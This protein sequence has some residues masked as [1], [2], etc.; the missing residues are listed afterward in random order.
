MDFMKNCKY[1]KKKKR[2]ETFN[3]IGCKIVYVEVVWF[4]L[5]TNLTLTFYRAVFFRKLEKIFK[6]NGFCQNH[7]GEKQLKD[8]SKGITN[9]SNN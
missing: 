6:K 7:L 8:N 2:S 4:K 9:V 1:Q 3:K 5:Q